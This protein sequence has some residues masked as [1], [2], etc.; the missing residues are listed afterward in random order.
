MIQK[1]KFRNPS[2]LDRIVLNIDFFRTFFAWWYGDVPIAILSL[3]KRLLLVINDNTSFSLVL[4]GYFRPWKNDY[5]I[6]G[7]IVG[8][9]IKTLYLPIILTFFIIILSIFIII[10]SIQLIILPIII[11]LIIVNPFLIA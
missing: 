8:I 6:A 11:G 3:L 5:N 7:W 1:V 9:F 4:F 2:A 10:I